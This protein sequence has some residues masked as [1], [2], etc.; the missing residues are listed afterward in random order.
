MTNKALRQ[1][2]LRYNYSSR[3]ATHQSLDGQ[4]HLLQRVGLVVKKHI[5]VIQGLIFHE[6]QQHGVHGCDSVGVDDIYFL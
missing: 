2:Q 5:G 6:H 1:H 3:S 4:C